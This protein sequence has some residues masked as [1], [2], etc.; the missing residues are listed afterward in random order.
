MNEIRACYVWDPQLIQQCD[1]LPAASMVHNLITAC[2]LISHLKVVRTS[3]ARYN[4]MKEFHSELYLDHLKSFEEIDDDYM[5]NSLDEE[6]GI[7][8]DCQPVSNMYGLVSTLAGGSLTAAKCL[9]LG[10]A[11]IAINWCGGWHHAHRFGAEGFC[12]VNDIVIA[13]EKLRRKFPKVLYIDL[14]VHHGNGVQ[15]AYNLSKS[16]FTFSMHKHEPG[17][18]PGTGDLDDIGSATGKGYTCNLPLH[19]Y[20]SDETFGYV[21]GKIF[22][23]I[24]S[25]FEPDAIVLQCGA[26][27]LAHDPHGGANLTTKGYSNCVRMVL[28]K[29]KPSMLLGGGGYKNQN[30]ARLWATLTALV[31]GVSLEECIPDHDEWVEY[32]PDY[33]M[34][35]EPTLARDINSMSYLDECVQRIRGNLQKYLGT[36]DA[37]IE[38]RAKRTKIDENAVMKDALANNSSGNVI[39]N[40]N[41][42]RFYSKVL[43]SHEKTEK[44]DKIKGDVYDFDD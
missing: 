15:D 2:G 36:N 7:G 32:G 9:I 8:Y 40:L 3:P 39:G 41:N 10:I 16:V 31:T 22:N 25:F 33:Q 27:A 43:T 11:D 21:F 34:K 17:F 14:D 42:N 5:S 26:D 12:Y 44:C 1:R 30:A 6:Y 29:R 28:D 35:V 37:A 24:Y 18:Y 20:Y 19:G 4:D 23:S 13:I 38:P